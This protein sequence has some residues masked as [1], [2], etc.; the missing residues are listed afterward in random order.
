MKRVAVI[1]AGAA[2]CFCTAWLRDLAPEL[3]VTVFEAGPQPLA[4]VAITGGGRCNLSNSFE[5]IRSLKEAYPRGERVMQRALKAFS[6]E[7]TIRWFTAHGVPCVLQ[8]D[9][10]WFPK[11]QDAMDVVNALLHAM[12]GAVLRCKTPVIPSDS[13]GSLLVNGAPYDFV[14]VTT[15]GIPK[16][17]SLLDLDIV[18]PVPSLFTFTV[19]DTALRSLMGL[20]VDASIGLQGTAFKAG[21]PLLITDWGFSG[22]ATLKLSSYA[23]RHLA[24]TGY[25]GTLAVNW[26]QKPENEVRELLAKTAA[27]HPQK[28]LSSVHPLPQRL[29]EHIIRKAEL[30]EDLRWAELG[31]KGLNKLVSVLTNDNYPLSGKSKFREEF[32]TAG[33]VAIGNIDLNTLAC[34]KHP[35][36]YF[37]GEVLD[38]DA[39]TGGFNLQ[40]AWSTGYVCARSIVNSL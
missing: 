31:S 17:F 2:G 35:G 7:D 10:C 6:Q 23:A 26:L 18:P 24:E 9:H 36:L 4:K 40:A 13:E 20:V 21:G 14:V 12:S 28:L 3:S 22:P 11:S 27:E 19:P 5:G 38:I 8:E 34:K 33:G 37:A 39:I 1:G 29:W 30:R 16:D 32:V 25:K 15:G